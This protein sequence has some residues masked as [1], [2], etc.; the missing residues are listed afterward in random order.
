MM[1][2]IKSIPYLSKASGRELWLTMVFTLN[3]SVY[4][5]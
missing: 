4:D 5:R 3:I 1:S 2:D